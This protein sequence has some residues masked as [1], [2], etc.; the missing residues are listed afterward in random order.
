MVNVFQP[1]R[2]TSMPK[3]RIMF[4]VISTYGFETSSPSTLMT[5]FSPVSGKAISNPVRNWLDTSPR[6]PT[7]PPARTTA[8]WMA[9]GG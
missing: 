7:V 8:G 4:N 1:S 3:R 6:T 5:V 2:A 9:R